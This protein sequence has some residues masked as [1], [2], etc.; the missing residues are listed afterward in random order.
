MGFLD[1]I[2]GKKEKT[3]KYAKKST[4]KNALKNYWEKNAKRWW[5]QP[6]APYGGACDGCGKP[7]EKG[8]GYLKGSRM[9]CE[10][11]TENLFQYWDEADNEPNYF[12]YREV[13]NALR[14]YK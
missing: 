14:E 8:E 11:C 5:S 3:K 7:L 12:G 1:S 9:R 13:E 2:F 10:E 6:S 4:E